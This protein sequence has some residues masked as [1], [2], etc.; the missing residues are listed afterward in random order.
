[1]FGGSTMGMR[2]TFVLLGGLP[3][4]LVHGV[5]LLW[6]RRQ[7]SSHVHETG[8][9][10]LHRRMALGWLRIAVILAAGSRVAGIRLRIGKGKP[11]ERLAFRC[12]LCTRDSRLCT[13]MSWGLHQAR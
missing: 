11:A 12:E 4:C 10:P 6:K 13:Y 3:V 1:M 8:Q 9:F 7:L 2:R 5:F